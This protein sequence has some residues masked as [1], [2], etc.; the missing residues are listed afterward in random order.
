M[1]TRI[2]AVLVF[3]L[4]LGV[5]SYAQT[6]GT[7]SLTVQP[8]SLPGGGKTVAGTD[9]GMT[10][11]PTPNFELRSDNIIAPGQN[12]EGYFGGFNYYLPI[13]SRKLNNASPNV[14]G[15]RLRFH[16]TASAGTD[17]ISLPGLPTKQHYA[18]LAGGGASYDLTSSGKW[19]LGVE[20]RYAKLPGLANNTAVVSLNPAFHF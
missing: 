13:L 20:V 6:Q 17:L 15:L 14:N 18:F 16:I 7:F 11:A 9:A 10:F 3:I 8:I 4:G 19:T 5:G 2:L 1:K 12:F